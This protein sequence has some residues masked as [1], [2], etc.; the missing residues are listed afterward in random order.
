MTVSGR[1]HVHQ[2]SR[3]GSYELLYSRC[4]GSESGLTLG[5]EGLCVQT[6]MNGAC[7]LST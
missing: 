6:T 2:K 4:E 7:A 5:T 1:E 3:M